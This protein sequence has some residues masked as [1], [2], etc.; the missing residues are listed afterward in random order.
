VV[1]A[2]YTKNQ[3]WR[4][5][6]DSMGIDPVEPVPLEDHCAYKYLFNFR[7]V[8]ASFRHRHLF[9]CNSL[10]FHVGNDYQEFYYDEMKPWVHYVPVTSTPNVG[11]S[12]ANVEKAIDFAL[13]NPDLAKRIADEGHR[14]IM[15]HL[16]VADV[17]EYWARLLGRYR[18]LQNWEV[19]KLKSGMV[20]KKRGGK[21]K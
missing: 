10:V 12:E 19:K 5:N 18:S 2:K 14:F 4:S 11:P 3:S 6:K 9:L 21:R 1:D 8:A 13:E 20:L 15:E 17:E 16:R 7:G